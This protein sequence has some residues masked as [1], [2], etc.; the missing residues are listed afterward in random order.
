MSTGIRRRDSAAVESGRVDP[1]SLVF[2]RHPAAEETAEMDSLYDAARLM[3][4]HPEY[5]A[6]G[7]VSAR[8]AELIR[9]GRFRI[10]GD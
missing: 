6:P 1:A 2:A 4:S 9:S 3:R 7:R 10:L 8:I 5:L